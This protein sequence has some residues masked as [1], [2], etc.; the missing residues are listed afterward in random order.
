MLASIL[1]SMPSSSTR[2]NRV[3]Q[4]AHGASRWSQIEN[5]LAAG[6]DTDLFADSDE[7]H[8]VGSGATE[9][10]QNDEIFG[11]VDHSTIPEAPDMLLPDLPNLS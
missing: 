11:S 9:K 3:S 2:V 6:E 7:L 8:L 10:I 4:E 1:Q 5:G